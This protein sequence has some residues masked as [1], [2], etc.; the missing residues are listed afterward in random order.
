MLTAIERL[1][2]NNN[3]QW[4]WL[5]KCDCGNTTKATTNQLIRGLKGSCGCMKKSDNNRKAHTKES[6]KKTVKNR[7]K[8]YKLGGT[9]IYKFNRN[10]KLSNNTSGYTGVCKYETKSGTRY[11]VMITVNKKSYSKSGFYT[12]D[13]AYD[14]RLKLEDELLPKNFRAEQKKYLNRKK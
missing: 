12:A 14:Y 9:Y 2:K 7:D 6:Y 8:E 5:C 13:E 3:M 10:K 11:K 1:E 4:I